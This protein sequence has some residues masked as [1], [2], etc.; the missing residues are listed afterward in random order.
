MDDG[1]ALGVCYDYRKRQPGAE[2]TGAHGLRKRPPDRAIEGDTAIPSEASVQSG[3]QRDLELTERE[4]RSSPDCD[5]LLVGDTCAPTN[6][7]GGRR[8]DDRSPAA[9]GYCAD[10]HRVIQVCVRGD[11]RRQP[12]EAIVENETVDFGGVADDRTV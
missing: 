4:F 8:S 7:N 10:I 11:D 12:I 5:E 9:V 2:L 6:Q 3:N 1:R